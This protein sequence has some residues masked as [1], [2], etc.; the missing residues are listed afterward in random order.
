MCEEFLLYE[1]LCLLFFDDLV[2]VV[3][4][5][6]VMMLGWMCG[7]FFCVCGVGV[8]GVVVVVGGVVV[9]IFGVVVGGVVFSIVVGL[10][11]E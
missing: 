11:F 10:I 7:L 4:C 6:E 9:G 5:V 8:G 2:C 1:C 3:G